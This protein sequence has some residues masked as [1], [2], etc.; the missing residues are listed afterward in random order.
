[1]PKATGPRNTRM[2]G[3]G[4]KPELVPGPVAAGDVIYQGTMVG[5]KAG[6]LTSAATAGVTEVIGRAEVTVDNRTG[7]EDAMLDSARRGVFDWANDGSLTAADVGAEVYVV[8]D[9]TVGKAGTVVAGKLL[10]M[11]G[12]TL[13]I[14]SPR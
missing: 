1:M 3:P 13:W 2:Y 4:T 11:E 6:K 8:D 7:T 9:T 10:W 12:A 14:E 5:R